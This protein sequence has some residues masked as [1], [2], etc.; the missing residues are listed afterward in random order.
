M[1]IQENRVRTKFRGGPQG[2]GRM[3]AEFAG[4][5][6]GCRTHASFITLTTNHYCFALQGGVQQLFHRHEKGV[7]V[8]VENK[9]HRHALTIHQKW[10]LAN[11]YPAISISH[12]D[13]QSTRK[14]AICPWAA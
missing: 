1:T 9:T 2:H 3:H 6:R 12:W 11:A 5:V 4:F 8:H 7:H 10:T 13:G 14:D